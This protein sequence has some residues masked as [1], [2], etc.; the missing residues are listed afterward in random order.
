MIFGI[1]ISTPKTC[2]LISR[3]NLI[4]A[5]ISEFRPWHWIWRWISFWIGCRGVVLWE[6]FHYKSKESDEG[7]KKSASCC[8]NCVSKLKSK[9]TRFWLI[10]WVFILSSGKFNS[11]SNSW[12]EE[13]TCIIKVNN[14]LFLLHFIN[15]IVFTLGKLIAHLRLSPK[16]WNPR[17]TTINL[18]LLWRLHYNRLA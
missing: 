18:C 4:N 7:R 13:Q 2:S 16:K 5:S 3:H 10:C 6:G 17:K 1:Q 12:N 15:L 14:A 9:S 11:Q 8:T